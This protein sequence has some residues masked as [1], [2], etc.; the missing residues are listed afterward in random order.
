MPGKFDGRVAFVTG[1]ASGMGRATAELLAE[2]GASVLLADVN[3]TGA[4][5]AA[6]DIEQRGGKARG[7][8]CDVSD[9]A[10]V[11]R[12]VRECVQA[13]GHLDILVNAAGI[14]RAAR[15]E[16][17]EEDEWRRVL[18]VNLTG[19]FLT[20]KAAL[21]HLL[22]RPGGRIVNVASIAGLRG[23]AYTSHYCASKAGLIHFTKSIALEFAGRGLRANCV[24][25][26]GVASPFVRAFMP[27]DDFER[28]LLAY[29]SPPVEGQ[30]AQPQDIARYIAFLA[31]PEAHVINGSVLVAD[32][33]T[34]A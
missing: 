15:F 5:E 13:F 33:G 17:I 8:A 10:S 19:P 2:E 24:C 12:A 31:S 25:P 28:Q 14:G 29:Y 7:L 21:P 32:F 6:K 26:G 16:E 4:E 30:F 9:A 11:N 18:D 27:R 34:T 3:G 1:A 23:Q 22:E 20:T